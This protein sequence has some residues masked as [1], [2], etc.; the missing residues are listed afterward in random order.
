MRYEIEN[1]KWKREKNKYQYKL[2]TKW[3]FRPTVVFGKITCYS[4]FWKQKKVPNNLSFDIYAQEIIKLQLINFKLQYT[5]CRE[6]WNI[7]TKVSIVILHNL[8][9]TQSDVFH[10]NMLLPNSLNT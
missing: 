4:N 9:F 5:L 10:D 8:M 2:L 3:L 1:E 7:P 6:Q